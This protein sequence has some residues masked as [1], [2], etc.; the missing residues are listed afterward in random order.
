MGVIVFCNVVVGLIL[1]C[2]C[3]I[4]LKLW[5]LKEYF[6][7]IIFCFFDINLFFKWIFIYFYWKFVLI[8]I[9]RMRIWRIIYVCVLVKLLEI[10]NKFKIVILSIFIFFYF[11]LILWFLNLKSYLI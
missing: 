5:I 9:Y 4:V 7:E 11:Y 1:V 6:C 8:E 3:D 10:R 2:I